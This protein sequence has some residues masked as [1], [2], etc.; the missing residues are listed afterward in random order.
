[1][2]RYRLRRAIR[3]SAAA[4]APALTVSAPRTMPFTGAKIALLQGAELLVYRRDDKPGLPFPNLWD[5]PGGG[6]EGDETPEDCVLRET[7]EEFGLTIAAHRIVW[8]LSMPSAK[9]PGHV[10]W[11]FVAF[12]TD[13]EI[14]SIRFGDEGQYWRMMPVEEYL[15]RD[16]AIPQLQD[17]LKAYQRSLADQTPGD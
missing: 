4:G 11:F 12:I 15:A 2:C 14:A 7:W 1:M 13:E 3:R 5:M 17:R 8:S 9:R 16:D 10:G 6:R